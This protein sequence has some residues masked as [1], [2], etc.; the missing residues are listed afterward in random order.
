MDDLADRFDI[1]P[2]YKV[3]PSHLT[4]KRGFESDEVD[5]SNLYERLDTFATTHSTSEY[6][7]TGWGQFPEKAIYIDVVASQ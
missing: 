4:L 6:S 3:M 5:M 2:F 1:S 7:L